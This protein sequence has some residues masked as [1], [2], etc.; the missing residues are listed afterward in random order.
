MKD[1]QYYLNLPYKIEIKKIP[2]E[3]GGGWGAFMP[4]FDKVALFFWGGGDGDTLDEALKDLKEAFECTLETL[5][6]E[7]LNI[8]E[9]SKNKDLAKNPAITLK[10]SL[11]KEIDEKALELGISRSALIALAAKKYIK[12]L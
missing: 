5:L 11:V 7:G 8:P 4:E 12:E 2:D 9:P 6:Q 3:E 1:L 10:E